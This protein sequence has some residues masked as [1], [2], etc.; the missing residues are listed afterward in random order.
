MVILTASA[1]NDIEE[2]TEEL[3]RASK[4]PMSVVII[5]MNKPKSLVSTD[6]SSIQEM[7]RQLHSGFE[8]YQERNNVIYMPVKDVKANVLLDY[9]QLM[10]QLQS[11]IMMYYK[12]NNIDPIRIGANIEHM[13]P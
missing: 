13:A 10:H 12:L 8:G 2:T 11:Q 4:V 1:P 6:F 3:V 5:S 9:K 7:E